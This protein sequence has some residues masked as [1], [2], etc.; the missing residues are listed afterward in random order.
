MSLQELKPKNKKARKRVGRG[1]GSGHGT[2]SCR[3][4]KG[5]S[6]R[7]GGRRR[8]GFEG[9]Q[10]PLYRKMPKLKGFKNPNRVEY[11]A[12]N[13]G[14]LEEM[15]K[16]GEVDF[17]NRKHPVK[18]LGTGEVTKKFA[19]KVAKASASAIEKIEKAGG[20]CEITK[21]KE[22]KETDKEVKKAKRAEERAKK[23]NTADATAS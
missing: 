4:Q 17:T 19:V 7:T 21:P 23:A 3:G 18:L 8:P 11:K 15:F 5:Q 6:S 16:E 1:N 2:Y 13:V 10:T 9:G 12:I 22:V 20:S 14:A